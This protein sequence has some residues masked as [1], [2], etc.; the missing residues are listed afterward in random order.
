MSTTRCFNGAAL[1]GLVCGLLLFAASV[2]AQSTPASASGEKPTRPQARPLHQQQHLPAELERILSDWAIASREIEKLEGEHHRVVYDTV[3]SVERWA[4]GQFFYESPDKGRIDIEPARTT[5]ETGNRR[6]QNG[7]PFRVKADKQ[8]KWISDGRNIIQIDEEN[9]QADVFQIPPRAQGQNIMN[10]PLPFLFGMPPAIAK[11]RYQLSL[12]TKVHEGIERIKIRAIPMWQQDIANWSEAWI[13]LDLKTYLPTHVKLV[14]PTGN[15]E[16][17]YIFK[18]LKVNKKSLGI[19]GNNPFRPRLRGY[20]ITT[21]TA[22]SL[23]GANVAGMVPDVRGMPWKDAGPILKKL[24]LTPSWLK[25]KA[26]RSAADV[27]RIYSQE[28]VPGATLPTD[29]K[30]R[31]TVFTKAQTTQ[32]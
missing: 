9:Q 27:Y 30:I 22:E 7:E 12:H 26:A 14:D 17:V 5:R 23:E 31:L 16:T 1:A 29:G 21:H 11:Q 2:R 6:D 24:G 32:R 19:F 8:E 3:F 4:E 15:T 13:M 18:K 20:K 28:P 10:G 25:G